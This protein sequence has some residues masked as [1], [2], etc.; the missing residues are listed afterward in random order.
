MQ[1]S[2]ENTKLI[3]VSYATV[4]TVVTSDNRLQ[5]IERV[6]TFDIT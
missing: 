1:R 5:H 6:T 2:L 3:T 4:R